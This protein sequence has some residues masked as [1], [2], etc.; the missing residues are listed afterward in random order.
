MNIQASSG[1]DDHEPS[2]SRHRVPP[3]LPMDAARRLDGAGAACVV[4]RTAGAVDF[5]VPFLSLLQIDIPTY[6]PDEVPEALG[7]IPVTKP[8]SR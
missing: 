4:D 3:A 2:E 7:A 6:A 8:G 1:A 5:G